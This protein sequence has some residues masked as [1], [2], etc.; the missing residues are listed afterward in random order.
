MTSLIPCTV[1]DLKL[2]TFILLMINQENPPHPSF[3]RRHVRDQG[4]WHII[5]VT[6]YTFLLD[7]FLFSVELTFK[8][9]V[10]IPL[11]RSEFFSY[12]ILAS[13]SRLW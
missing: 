10:C 4:K 9:T 5:L 1:C 7:G 13:F 11:S 3:S 2:A 12:E 8:I 6:K